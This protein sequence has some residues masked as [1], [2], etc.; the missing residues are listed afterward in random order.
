LGDRLGARI[1]GSRVLVTGARGMLGSHLVPQLVA[2]GA[3]VFATSR[4]P[5]CSRAD[6][7]HWLQ[8][9]FRTRADLER[10][11]GEID[12][13][14]VYPLAGT[15]SGAAALDHVLPSFH[16][17]LESTVNWLE[18]ATRRGRPRVVLSGSFLEPRRAD[19]EPRLASGY[20]AA[21]WAASSYAR[22]FFELYETPVVTSVPFMVY[23]PHQQ[24]SKLVPHVAR[25][26]LAGRAPEIDNPDYRADWVYAGDIGE[27]LVACGFEPRAPGARIDLGTGEL[28]SVREVVAEIAAQIGGPSPRFGAGRTGSAERVADPAVAREILGWAPA[29]PLRRGIEQTIAW[30]RA[31]GSD[32]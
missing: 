25:C 16:S 12:P 24:E 19:G 3:R 14:V 21:K 13:D 11:I 27:A 20:A 30:V 2:Q 9:E 1:R 32:R 17:L 31:R 23:G 26:L 7:V 18:L 29:T 10:V 4:S 8:G 28:I 5:V 6:G 15:V 22:M